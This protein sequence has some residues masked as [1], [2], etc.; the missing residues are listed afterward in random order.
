VSKRSEI[1]THALARFM[2]YMLGHRPDEFGLVPDREGFV[3]YKE[4]LWAIHEEPGWGYVRMGHI[5]EVLLGNDRALFQPEEKRIRAL[6]RSWHLDLDNPSPLPPKSLFVAVRRRAHPVVMEKG[7][8]ST[9]GRYSVLSP[10]RHMALRIGR[11][12]DQKPVIL[13]IM[14]SSA[15]REGIQFYPFGNLFLTT[16]VPAKFISGPPASPESR[17]ARPPSKAGDKFPHGKLRK[18]EERRPDFE[19]G[20]FVLDLKRDPDSH[21]RAKGKKQK[22]W[23]EEARKMRR[24]KRQ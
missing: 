15:Q 10:D 9:E 7:I 3:T 11:R 8:A 12:R 22:G 18:I 1:K 20:T 21:R 6:D 2:F 23:K 4:F 5:N 13:K 14:A 16:Q 19:A 24:K 17:S